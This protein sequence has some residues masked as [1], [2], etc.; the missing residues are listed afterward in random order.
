MLKINRSL[1]LLYFL[2]FFLANGC[3]KKKAVKPNVYMI[4]PNDAEQSVLLS[5]FVD[6]IAYV[7]LETSE[8]S[9]MVRVGEIIIKNQY[10]Y[11]VDYGQSA[12]LVFDKKGKFV[13]KLAKVGEGPDEY[14][15]LGPVFISEDE[16]FVEIIDF[17]D[18]KSRILKFSNI[19]FKLLDDRKF[20]A[21]RAN[22]WKRENDIY[23]F[24]AQQNDNIVNGKKTNGDIVISTKSGSQNVLFDK[25]I[26]TNGNTF[27]YNTESFIENNNGEIFVSLMYN[28]TFFRLSDM[29]AHPILTVDFGKYGID[30]SLGQ[31]A[32]NEQKDY[33]EQGATGLAFLPVLNIYKPNLV[34]LTY[35]YKSNYGAKMNHYLHL[36]ESNK[37][38][39]TSGIENDLSDFPKNVYICSFSYSIKHSPIYGDYLVHV[40]LPEFGLEKNGRNEIEGIGVVNAED[41]PV[42]MLMKLKE[43]FR[44]K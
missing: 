28:N 1:Y 10:I 44:M 7:K 19:S 41:N 39:H 13:S 25:N 42:I 24:A 38:F 2:Y 26:T 4:N 22:S 21:P 36:K 6:S 31:K 18:E 35:N 33:L 8:E 9:M 32:T 43:E 27:N 11:A 40:V 15:R 16:K 34:S 14:K 12:V 23:Y 3:Q 17:V 5:E 37:I 29:E 20:F 30:N